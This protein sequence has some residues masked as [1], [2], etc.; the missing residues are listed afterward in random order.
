MKFSTVVTF[1]EANLSTDSEVD[2]LSSV[3]LYYPLVVS[4]W[5]SALHARVRVR[6]CVCVLQNESRASLVPSVGPGEFETPFG[7]LFPAS[8][9]LDK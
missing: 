2:T 6:V 9:V 7:D 1:L 8:V 3:Q 4:L 5:S